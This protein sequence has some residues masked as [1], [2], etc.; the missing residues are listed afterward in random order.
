[1][2]LIVCFLLFFALL[3][4]VVPAQ[5]LSTAEKTTAIAQVESY[6]NKVTT[7]RAHF[8]QA[9]QDGTIQG[10]IFTWWRPGR[11]RFQYDPPN[12]DYIVADGLLLHYWDDGVKNY[13]NAPIGTTLA[14]FLLRK[15]I[16]LSGDLKVVSISR[17]AKNNLLVTLIQRANAE[18][19]DLRLLFAEKPMQLLKWRVTDGAG[20]VTEVTLTDIETG[21]RLN[22]NLF[23]FK[24]PKGYDADWKNR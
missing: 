13:S 10:G 6:F 5:E 19:G 3:P 23:R 14:D 2:R 8:V 1:M 7:V 16:K 22:P 24:P 4:V 15:K 20:Q 17:P 11:L 12:G 9:N 21:I 18:A